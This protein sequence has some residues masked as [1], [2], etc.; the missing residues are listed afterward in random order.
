MKREVARKQINKNKETELSELRRKYKQAV[1]ET[2]LVYAII[3]ALVDEGIDRIPRDTCWIRQDLK[4]VQH[5]DRA[6]KYAA[7]MGKY[8]E[9]ACK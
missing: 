1:E 3:D 7:L 2:E 6:S 8:R 5:L 9:E 4:H